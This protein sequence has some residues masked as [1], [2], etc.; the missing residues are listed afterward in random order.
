MATGIFEGS[1]AGRG[2]RGGGAEGQGKRRGEGQNGIVC[3]VNPQGPWSFLSPTCR[4]R[5]ERRG[6]E[7]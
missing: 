4:W 3:H 2:M 5:H 6:E 7:G 1:F